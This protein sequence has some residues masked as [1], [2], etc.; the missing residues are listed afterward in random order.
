[1]SLFDCAIEVQLGKASKFS[2]YH[3]FENG[4]IGVATV[5]RLLSYFSCLSIITRD[6]GSSL[7]YRIPPSSLPHL[8]PPPLHRLLFYVY[9]R[10]MTPSFLK[11]SAAYK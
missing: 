11:I 4:R 9:T 3:A 6:M 2:R 8:F 10:S 7:S 5:S 1:M